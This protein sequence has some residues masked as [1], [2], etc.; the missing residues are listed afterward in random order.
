MADEVN[1]TKSFD[2]ADVLQANKMG[3]PLDVA[4]KIYQT[5]GVGAITTAIGDT[6]FGI[7]HRQTPNAVGINRDVYGLTFF[8][9]PMMNMSTVNLRHD[10]IMMPLLNTDEASLPRAIRCTLDTELAKPPF[11][12]KSTWVDRQQAFI[13]ILTNNL[14]SM[15]GWPDIVAPMFESPEGVYKETFAMVDGLTK[16]YGSFTL[17]ANFRN[18][19]GDPIT[20]M[21][22]YWCHYASLVFE[23]VLAPY[24][25]NIINRRLDYTTRI[26]R[27]VLD[28]TKS[29][30]Q[31]I[32]MCG[33]AIPE[34]SPMGAAM[35]FEADRPLNQSNDQISINFRC[36]GAVYQ[37][38][39][40]IDQF[41]KTVCK[42]NDAM[43]D[44]YRENYY[45][46]VPM[47]MLN[48]FNNRGYPRINPDN[49]DMEWWVENQEF[50]S[51]L[52]F[53]EYDPNALLVAG[54]K[55]TGGVNGNNG[56]SIA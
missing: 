44:R 47:S 17:T 11:N 48:I 8:T 13:P 53:A 3:K 39:L 4:D 28:A 56:Q 40:I 24:P 32:A 7:N 22:M 49:L 35:N 29:K 41:N 18:I 27:V 16:N 43:S 2:V 46:K 14:L 26:Y 30:V 19:P 38:Y 42:Q 45:T 31:K 51:R 50:K 5:G 6:M 33:A 25:S 55:P 20:A 52:G 15:S 37:D 23:G 21:F 34:N 12:I 54:I 36:V 1:Q 10:R 9:R